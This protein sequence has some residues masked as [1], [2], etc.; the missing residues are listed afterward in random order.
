MVGFLG[1]VGIGAAGTFAVCFVSGRTPGRCLAT[2]AVRGAGC[3]TGRRRGCLTGE[4]SLITILLYDSAQPA[5]DS[6]RC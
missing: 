4:K 1:I 2:L 5:I 3:F 6:V